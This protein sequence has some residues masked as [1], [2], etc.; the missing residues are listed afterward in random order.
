M[1]DKVK[2]DT[3]LKE[4]EYDRSQIRIDVVEDGEERVYL[5]YIVCPFCGNHIVT[6]IYSCAKEGKFDL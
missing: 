3:C 2:C 1:E 4:M 6:T 5:E